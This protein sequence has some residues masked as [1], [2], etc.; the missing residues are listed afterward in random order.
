MLVSAEALERARLE[1]AD[2]RLWAFLIQPVSP[3]DVPCR[4]CSAPAGEGCRGRLVGFC[5]DPSAR[6]RPSYREGV[7]A[8]FRTCALAHGGRFPCPEPG[9]GASYF[10]SCSKEVDCTTC[11]QGKRRVLDEHASRRR[12]VN[13]VLHAVGLEGIGEPGYI[14]SEAWRRHFWMRLAEHIADGSHEGWS[15]DPYHQLLVDAKARGEDVLALAQKLWP[16]REAA[17]EAPKRA[18]APAVAEG[19]SPPPAV[20]R[21]LER[22]QATLSLFAK[23]R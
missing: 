3:L 1:L 19:P 14:K 8:S 2:S 12:L 4:P 11:G 18:L 9:C 20:P 10:E 17:Q 15:N 5:A 23:P 6:Y 16:Q 22:Q 7:L 21:A 13:A